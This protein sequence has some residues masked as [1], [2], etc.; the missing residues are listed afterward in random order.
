[1][2]SG[3][4]RLHDLLVR[5]R[6]TERLRVATWR[7]ARLEGARGHPVRG[8]ADADAEGV[9]RLHREAKAAADV[10]DPP[11][12]ARALRAAR[13]CR[14]VGCSSDRFERYARRPRL[15]EER[16]DPCPALRRIGVRE[17]D[18]VIG[19]RDVRDERLVAVEDPAVAVASR[20]R[21]QARDVAAASGSVRPNAR[22]ARPTRCPGK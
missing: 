8:R 7:A 17:H 6:P 14:S 11:R 4:V 5:E 1:V 18:D 22:R 2:A 12:P 15:D 13:S 16:G 3:E 19:D 20:G 9:E 10:A 21:A